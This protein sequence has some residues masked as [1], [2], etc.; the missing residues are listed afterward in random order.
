METTWTFLKTY[1]MA[2]DA[3]KKMVTTSMITSAITTKGTTVVMTNATTIVGAGVPSQRARHHSLQCTLRVL[4]VESPC[5][6]TLSS[7]R[8]AAPQCDAHLFVR[9]AD[10]NSKMKPN[11]V[12]V[13]ARESDIHSLVLATA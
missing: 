13:A 12:T 2:L 5:L 4:A 11:F 6:A 8:I 9:D 3:R 7:A 1:L 10:C